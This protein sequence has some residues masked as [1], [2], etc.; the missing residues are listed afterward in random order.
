MPKQL[1]SS[2]LALEERLDKVEEML[3]AGISP[4]RIERTLAKDYGI[5][6]RQAR[7]YI[8][9]VYQRWQAQ[10]RDDAPH[11]RE[12]IIRMTERFYARA[13]SDKQ[14]TAA[15]NALALLAKMS[16]AFTQYD[17]ER[18][19]RLAALGPPPDDP[20]LAL[21]WA[22][23]CMIFALSEVVS[24]PTL[25]P[26][27]RLRW[28][29]EIGGKIG[30]THSKTLVQAKLD[31]V[32][33]RLCGAGEPQSEELAPA[34]AVAWPADSRTGAG[35]T[36]DESRGGSGPGA[37]AQEDGRDPAGRRR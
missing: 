20:T 23:R 33:V 29:A 2:R 31:E 18:E 15:A 28:I 27:R 19:R 16:G 17:P 25:D 21:V 36:A 5:T 26:E 14:F 12:K 35:D 10:T 34:V 1:K 13:L 7:S 9:R 32:T 24:H 11:R 37:A 6:Q 30:M 8:G 22:Q 3:C 4:G